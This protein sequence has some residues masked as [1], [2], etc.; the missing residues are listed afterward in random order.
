M[1][2]AGVLCVVAM[3]AVVTLEVI[4]RY[5]FNS[6]STWADEIASYLLIA[7]VFLGLAQDLRLDIHIRID[8]VTSLVSARV[9]AYL[10]V[11]AYVIGIF[12]SI[13]LAIGVWTRFLNFW[14]RNTTSDSLLM[15]PLWL[16]MIPVLLGAFVFVLAMVIG[17]LKAIVDLSNPPSSSAPLES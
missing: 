17:C 15:T 5:V 1:L 9:R 4:S 2:Y 3:M 14:T 16:P 10:G 8:V 12:F 13:L 7:I 11:F 6:P